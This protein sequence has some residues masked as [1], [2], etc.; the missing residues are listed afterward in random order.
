MT[1]WARVQLWDNLTRG[2]DVSTALDF[3]KGLGIVTDVL[4]QTTVT[5]YQA[6]E[7]INDLFDKLVVLDHGH[8]VYFGLP[9]EARAYSEELGFKSPPP[10]PTRFRRMNRRVRTTFTPGRPP[11]TYLQLQELLRWPSECLFTTRRRPND[12]V[13]T[14][15]VSDREHVLANRPDKNTSITH[16]Y[17]RQFLNGL[18]AA[19]GGLD[20]NTSPSLLHPPTFAFDKNTAEGSPIGSP[21]SWK[22]ACFDVKDLLGSYGSGRRGGYAIAKFLKTK[23]DKVGVLTS[24][25]TSPNLGYGPGVGTNPRQARSP[26]TARLFGRSRSHHSRSAS[27]RRQDWVARHP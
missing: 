4:G 20:I 23:A 22:E 19:D 18:E 10:E 14:S 25:S 27:I 7:G 26:S 21:P 17:L 8:Q 13:L 11:S 12:Y 16:T 24:I 3:V 6:G 2:L 1:T 15:S 5:L 9:S